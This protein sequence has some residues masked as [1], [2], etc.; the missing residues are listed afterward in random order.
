MINI[1]LL[2]SLMYTGFCQDFI[3]RKKVK[4][5]EEKI[6]VCSMLIRDSKELKVNTILVLSIA[7]E[8]SRFTPQHKPT[9]FGCI[10]PLQI[11][12]KY[13]CHN[14]KLSDC[15]PFYDGVK[16]IKYYLKRFKPVKRAICYYNDARKCKKNNE[17]IYTLNVIKHKLLMKKILI[18]K[19][20]DIL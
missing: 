8:E 10:G 1:I 5:T 16:T 6:E 14:K 18:E 19:S 7:W 2:S 11:K 3:K 13:W 9:R 12:I 17:S 20:I 4:P 15:D